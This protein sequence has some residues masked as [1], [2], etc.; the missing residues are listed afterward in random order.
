MEQEQH[1]RQ[2]LSLR[3]IRLLQEQHQALRM[4]QRRRQ[5]LTPGVIRLQ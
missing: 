5:R 1:R 2:R 4:N 3:K